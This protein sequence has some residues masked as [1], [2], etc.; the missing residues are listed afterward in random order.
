[1][2]IHLNNIRKP[3]KYRNKQLIIKF[4]YLKYKNIEYVSY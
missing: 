2:L 4:Y 1:M 3:L